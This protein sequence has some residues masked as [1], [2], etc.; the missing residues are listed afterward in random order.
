M[1]GFRDAPSR[2]NA[3]APFDY[4]RTSS[5]IH[6]QSRYR[7]FD[8]DI[9]KMINL[10]ESFNVQRLPDDYDSVNQLVMKGCLGQGNN[11]SAWLAVKQYDGVPT[12][13]TV[14]KMEIFNDT[15]LVQHARSDWVVTQTAVNDLLISWILSEASIP[16][17]QGCYGYR[18]VDMNR[19][20]AKEILLYKEYCEY[21]MESFI[22]SC[23]DPELL[24]TNFIIHILLTV[25]C[26]LHTEYKFY[27]WDFKP[28]NIFVKKTDIEYIDYNFEG[29]IYRI[30][31]F[32]WCPVISDFGSSTINRVQGRYCTI[33]RHNWRDLKATAI[34]RFTPFSEK[35]F[36]T[37]YD[38]SC[39]LASSKTIQPIKNHH[40]TDI[41]KFYM[42]KKLTLRDYL[43]SS[44]VQ[45]IINK[46]IA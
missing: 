22:R 31:L 30:P 34:E 23:E 21:N 42:R 15:P 17:I 36:D 10:L 46:Y 8:E 6:R 1:R 28:R 40:L 26:V 5:K 14:K 18:I 19:S 43:L 2:Y 4:G 39:L 13:I 7:S 9:Q 20:D 12:Y 16:T 29:E 41:F 44:D 45:E 24:L 27:H 35:R 37:M 3:N 11:S 33:Q 32:G 25:L 38:C